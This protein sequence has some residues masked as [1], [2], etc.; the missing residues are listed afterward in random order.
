MFLIVSEQYLQLLFSIGIQ[1]LCLNLC[2]TILLNQYHICLGGSFR[3][4]VF[5]ILTK[6][7]WKTFKMDFGSYLT[8]LSSL[9][10]FIVSMETLF[11]NPSSFRVFHSS[12][13]LP[14]FQVSFFSKQF[15]FFSAVSFLTSQLVSLQFSWSRGSLDFLNLLKIL[16]LLFIPSETT[17][18][19][20]SLGLPYTHLVLQDSILSM[21]VVTF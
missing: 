10:A 8:T 15:L 4:N 16:Y 7:V 6:K 12:S 2:K 17:L 9:R 11:G 1:W 5:A 20:Y 3:S 13:G 18:S 14:M 19:N 21:T